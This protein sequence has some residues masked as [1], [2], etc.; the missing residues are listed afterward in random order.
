MPASSPVRSSRRNNNFHRPCSLTILASHIALRFRTNRRQ[1]LERPGPCLLETSET[2]IRLSIR[3]QGKAQAATPRRRQPAF[4]GDRLALPTLVDPY[5]G[6]EA[7]TDYRPS[8]HLKIKRWLGLLERFAYPNVDA[9]AQVRPASRLQINTRVHM[10]HSVRAWYFYCDS[11][12]PHH[13]GV[14]ILE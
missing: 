13:C 5:N 2:Y 7:R 10:L 6:S 4:G 11:S 3:P 14:K 12:R 8:D 9:F 1:T